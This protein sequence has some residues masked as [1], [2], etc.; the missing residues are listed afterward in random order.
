MAPSRDWGFWNARNHLAM[1]AVVDFAPGQTFGT[2]SYPDAGYASKGI[3]QADPT[4]GIA[5]D[6]GVLTLP[7]SGASPGTS[8]GPAQRH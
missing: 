4:G 5:V 2:F 8:Q 1:D 3:V 7:P 6:S